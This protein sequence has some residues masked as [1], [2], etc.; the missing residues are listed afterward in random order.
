MS[1]APIGIF[2]SGVGGL[3]VWKEVK[4]LLPNENIIYL[5]DSKNCPYG[6][7]PAHEIIDYSI[8][9]TEFLLS[10]KCKIIVVACNTAT[11]SA[12]DT[13]RKK[14]SIPFVGMEPAIKPAALHTKTG[15]IGILATTGTF[16]G[17]LF[18][19][20]SSKYANNIE[21]I[22]QAG[23]GLVELVELNK[24]NSD[25]A[26][27]LISKYVLPMQKLGIDKLVLGCTHYPFFKTIIEKITQG[28]IEV[29]DPAPAIAQRTQYLLNS[30][31]MSRKQAN[32]Q[33]QFYTTG[34]PDTLAI[35]INAN[36]T[37]PSPQIDIIPI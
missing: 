2:D 10:K 4:K 18:K 22:I 7:K 37:I 13:L 24:Q 8:K 12:I 5:A 30:F 19:Q 31:N 14:Y 21:T 15:K 23:N 20:T 25:E 36:S 1:N 29:I 26:Y 33:Y 9:N 16:N 32:A 35:L 6:E 11:A 17:R 34:T 28:S 27:Q 3:S